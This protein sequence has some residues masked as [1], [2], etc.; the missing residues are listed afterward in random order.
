MFQE[1]FRCNVVI[2]RIEVF[3]HYVLRMNSSHRLTQILTDQKA[4]FLSVYLWRKISR[5]LQNVFDP[6]NRNEDPAG[7]MV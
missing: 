7:T 5:N 4:E 2:D 3:V 6:A 1:M